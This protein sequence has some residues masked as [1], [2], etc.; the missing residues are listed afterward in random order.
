MEVVIECE[1]LKGKQGQVVIKELSLAAKVILHTIHFRSPY[2]MRTHGSE[3]NQINW[4]DGIIPYEQVETA[5]SEAIAG[6][7]HLYSYGITK[8]KFLS[9]LLSRHAMNLEDLVTPITINI[10]QDTVASYLAIVLV[11]S[12]AQRETRIPSS[13]G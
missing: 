2:N 10:G 4:D 13:S 7:A 9:D 5:L 8:C 3:E 11:I 1:F 12:V 6:Y